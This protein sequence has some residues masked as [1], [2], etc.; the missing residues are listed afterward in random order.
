MLRQPPYPSTTVL[1]RL[2]I[3][4]HRNGDERKLNLRHY[5]SVKRKSE[6]EQCLGNPILSQL[7][8][9]AREQQHIAEL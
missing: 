9:S 6:A 1:Q 8:I 2:T 3:H 5:Q 4:L 7:R